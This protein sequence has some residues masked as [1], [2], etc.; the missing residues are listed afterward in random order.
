[1]GR[2]ANGAGPALSVV[3]PATN[4]PPTLSRCLTAI[5]EAASE[6]DEVL[7]IDGPAGAGPSE[8]RNLGARRAAR[9]VVVFV[10]AD[11][12]VH[13]DALARIRAAFADDPTLTALFGSYDDAPAAPGVVSAF[14]NLLHHHVHHEAAGDAT[15]F[16]AGLGAVRRSAF[17]EAGGFDADLFPLPS[18]EDIDLGMRLSAAGGRIR[19]DP[20]VQG[21]HLKAWRLPEMLRTDFARRGVPWVGLVLRSGRSSTALNLGWRHRASALASLLLA[22][23]LLRRRP[24]QTVAGATIL[25]ALN[26]PFYRLLVRRRGVGEAAV[27]VA[28]HAL[29]HLSGIAAVP[30]GVLKHLSRRDGR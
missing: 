29:H 6:A 8:A 11:V 2:G 16:W 24:R 1:M 22:A 4:E 20:A 18:V 19:L 27:G 10:D 9:D 23:S 14:R 26:V 25:V 21:T 15:T 5:H 7:V 30:V 13:A 3:V 28:L 17:L 12:V